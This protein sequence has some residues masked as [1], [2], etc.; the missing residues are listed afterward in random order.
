MDMLVH[1][2]STMFVFT[3]LLRNYYVASFPTSNTGGVEFFIRQSHRTTL[4][5]Y[6]LQDAFDTVF[7]SEDSFGDLKQCP[8]VA[9]TGADVAV[10]ERSTCPWYYEINR[11]PGRHPEVIL[12]A[13]TPCTSSCIGRGDDYQCYPIT[14]NIQVLTY[15]QDY[16]STYRIYEPNDIDIT[17]GFTCGSRKL[18]VNRTTS[19]PLTPTFA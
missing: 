18:T 19:R 14:R 13:V 11:D 1:P 10:N 7:E 6:G 9:K 15:K 16:N 5:N 3:S 12:N 8:T 2:V 4:H 17:V